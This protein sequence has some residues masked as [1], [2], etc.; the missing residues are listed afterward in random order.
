MTKSTDTDPDTDPDTRAVVEELLCRI[1]E[2]DPERI[3]ALYADGVDRR[4][5]RPEDG[6]G[7]TETPWIRHRAGRAD[8]A[9]HYRAWPRVLVDGADAV[10]LG[11]SRQTAA[12][13]GHPY[14]AGFALHLTVAYGLT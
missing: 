7:R 4:L 5:S 9:D 11:E 8:A 1:G 14:R 6:H 3:A 10:V 13:T 2:G 12:H